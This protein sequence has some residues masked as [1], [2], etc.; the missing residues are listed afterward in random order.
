MQWLQICFWCR[1]IGSWNIP[2]TA[3]WSAQQLG[4]IRSLLWPWFCWRHCTSC[5]DDLC[6]TAGFWSN[7]HLSWAPGMSINRTKTKMQN[8]GGFDAPCQHVSVQWNEVEVVE[9]FVYLGSPI[10]AQVVASWKS[11]DV[12]LLSVSPCLLWI[13]ISGVLLSRWQRSSGYI[14][15]A[16]YQYSSIDLRCG[17]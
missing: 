4:K 16:F 8:L 10:I 9:S 1:W 14:M 13:R 12:P 5:W 3:A 15:R 6:P 11:S 2:L 17:L 7:G